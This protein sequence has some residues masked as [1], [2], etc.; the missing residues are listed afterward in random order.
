MWRL[1][2]DLTS[3]YPENARISHAD[4][5][6][7]LADRDTVVVCD[8]VSADSGPILKYHWHGHPDAAW[9]I[10]EGQALLYLDGTRLW[11]TCA[12]QTLEDGQIDR[13]PGSRGQLTLSTEIADDI[14]W[15]VFTVGDRPSVVQED[16]GLRVDERI[17]SRSVRSDV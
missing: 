16:K 10:E 11:V 17:F 13:L 2:V 8:T 4:R 12:G 7:W 5:Q 1:T 15:W 6:V 9:W 3:C 14:V